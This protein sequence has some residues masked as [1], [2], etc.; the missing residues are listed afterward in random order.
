MT[1]MLSTNDNYNTM[2][3][4]SVRDYEIWPPNQIVIFTFRTRDAYHIALIYAVCHDRKLSYR[5]IS[6]CND[7]FILNY[8]IIL[9]RSYD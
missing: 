1:T 7:I 9:L 5:K 2:D 8:V 4:I 3:T 6:T